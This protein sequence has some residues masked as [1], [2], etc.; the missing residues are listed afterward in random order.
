MFSYYI[1]EKWK[2]IYDDDAEIALQHRP[3]LGQIT[4]KA[5]VLLP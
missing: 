5:S 2:M 3:P 4:T 1:Q